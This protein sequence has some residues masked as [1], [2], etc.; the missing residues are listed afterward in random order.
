MYTLKR[1]Y[2]KELSDFFCSKAIRFIIGV[3]LFNLFPALSDAQEVLRGLSVNPE[4][5]KIS[6]EKH[7][8]Q[9]KNTITPGDTLNLPFWDDFSGKSSFPNSLLWINKNAYVNAKYAINPPSNGVV[10]LDALNQNRKLYSNDTSK[11]FYADTLTSKPINLFYPGRKD[12]FLSFFYQPQGAGNP[13]DPGDSLILEFYHKID[14]AHYEWKKQEWS[15]PGMPL[16][17]FKE[18]ILPI[19]TPYLEKD[20][21]F[22]FRNVAYRKGKDNSKVELNSLWHIDNVR[23]DLNRNAND[24]LSWTIELPFI[25]D[26][27]TTQ[28]Y[29]DSKLWDDKNVFINSAYQVNPPTIG[30]AT[31]DALDPS[32]H[33]Y[34]NASSSPFS[35]DTLTSK[36]INLGKNKSSDSIYFSYFIQPQ[37]LGDSPEPGDSL[38]LEF[39][40]PS[41]PDSSAWVKIKNGSFS[42][43]TL[44][45]FKQ[46]SPIKVENDYLKKG[47]RFRFRNLAS[48]DGSDIAGKHSNVDH[49]NIDYIRLDTS[50][51]VNDTII[52]DI[53]FVAP[54]TSLLKTYQSMPWN[55]YL[56]A[57]ATE[58]KPTLDVTYKNLGTDPAFISRFFKIT[59]MR[60]NGSIVTLNA[61]EQS[62]DPSST[63]V[64]R[65][66]FEG[67]DG[68]SYNIPL[69][70]YDIKGYIGNSP[71]DARLENDTTHYTQIF[72]NYFAY[73]DS[74][75]EAGYGIVGEG[76][77]NASVA[78]SFESYLPDTLTGVRF[79]FNPT[80]HDTTLSYS[81]NLAVWADNNGIPGEQIYS[82]PI[83]PK[84]T[85]LNNFYTFKLDSGIIVDGIFYVGFNQT[86]DDFLNIGFDVNNNNQRF[87]FFNT[88]G[89]WINSTKAGSLMI[90]PVMGSNVQEGPVAVKPIV[91]KQTFG[92]YPNPADNQV[93]INT[94]DYKSSKPLLIDV[95]DITGKL[96]LSSILNENTLDVSS[97]VNGLYFLKLSGDNVNWQPIKL[98]IER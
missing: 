51:N 97:L 27:S 81:F 92:I 29:P 7:A 74:T 77:Q 34:K 47:F 68:P 94:G 15:K 85:T 67:F 76:A 8:K 17:P 96:V 89:Q 19:D 41:L 61:E 78:Y 13:L 4:L 16:Q 60:N 86:S 21:R 88:N 32:G 50:R 57:R 6:K 38:I 22:R 44:K 65:T 26:F 54:I 64:L 58:V 83:N 69:L 5:V 62:I 11:Y 82:R 52:K 37:G 70:K 33:L 75:S 42:G 39:Y 66:L 23:L 10:T 79:Y 30:V 71:D 40:N 63:L 35:S 36:R 53:A 46:V 49:W 1:F 84:T 56:I 18:E 95:Y 93:Y 24:S 14:S 45:E 25:D 48:I 90:R 72:S 73:D 55:Q 3:V 87:L 98:L 9:L 91:S 80:E 28:V 2:G 20:F 12:I 59:E 43:S 31:F